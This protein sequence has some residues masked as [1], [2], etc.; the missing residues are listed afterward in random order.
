MTIINILGKDFD[1]NECKSW[2]TPHGC[3]HCTFSEICDNLNKN[4]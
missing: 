4:M 2:Q 3:E 1:T